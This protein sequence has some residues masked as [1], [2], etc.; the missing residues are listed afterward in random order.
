MENLAVG[1][2]A[3]D[4]NL[5]DFSG[6]EHALKDYDKLILYFY[7]RDN[8]PG[9][10]AEA[11]SLRDSYSE[12]TSLGYQILGVSGDSGAS[13]ER[14]TAKYSLPFPL[15]IDTD[16]ALCNAYGVYG[17]KKFMGKTS[18]GIIRKTF[19]IEGGVITHIVDKVKTKVHAEQLLE[20][21]NNK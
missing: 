11:C 2:V 12:L 8:T 15:L 7:P 19:I 10:S 1:S 3:P 14:F 4:F 9:C 5:L 6:K 16:K 18:M 13:H 21:I 20:I 17:E